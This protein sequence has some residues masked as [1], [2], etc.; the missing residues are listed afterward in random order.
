VESNL[1]VFEPEA[2]T[3]PRKAASVLAT[4]RAVI[5]ASGVAAVS[6]IRVPA[7]V[8]RFI[9]D[10]M[11]LENRGEELRPRTRGARRDLLFGTCSSRGPI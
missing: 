1:H 11:C 2:L 4:A 7:A 6:A 9:V 5:R 3:K 8:R 10:T